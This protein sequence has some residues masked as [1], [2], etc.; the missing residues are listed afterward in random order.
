MSHLSPV[1]VLWANLLEAA[2][3]ASPSASLSRGRRH[4][5]RARR[6]QRRS[7]RFSAYA[8]KQCAGHFWCAVPCRPERVSVKKREKRVTF[9]PFVSVI[10]FTVE[11]SR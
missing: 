4:Q 11:P 6:Q 1:A 5:H 3:S 2:A 10:E 8:S 7:P 9:S